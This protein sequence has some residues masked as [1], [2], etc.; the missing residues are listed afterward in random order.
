MWQRSQQHQQLR[1]WNN[2]VWHFF[3][4]LQAVQATTVVPPGVSKIVVRETVAATLL[5]AVLV[6]IRCG[7]DRVS[8]GVLHRNG[9]K[10]VAG[11]LLGEESHGGGGDQ[12]P[13][14]HLSSGDSR[15]RA[16]PALHSDLLP[17]GVVL[18]GS[19]GHPPRLHRQ[20][21]GCGLL[22]PSF[23]AGDMRENGS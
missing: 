13:S 4:G 21:V 8:D 19:L 15:H 5:V 20:W 12:W 7:V 17:G 22:L 18:G 2:S 3:L 23:C 1:G 9:S 16:R 14:L 6:P 10:W 11:P